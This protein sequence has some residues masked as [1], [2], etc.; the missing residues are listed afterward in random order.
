MVGDQVEGGT[1][2]VEM[3]SL[4]AP[5]NRKSFLLCLAVAFFYVS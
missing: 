1:I 5:N 2:Q 4:T 3:E